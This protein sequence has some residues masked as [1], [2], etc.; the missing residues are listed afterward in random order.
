[1]STKK[2]DE[3]LEKLRQRAKLIGIPHY[4]L[5]SKENLQ[6]KVNLAL[7]D[8]AEAEIS[9]E[10]VADDHR[11]QWE[12]A[13]K[14]VRLRISN[15]NPDNRE[16]PGEVIT[17][18]SKVTGRVSKFVPFDPTFSAN[19]YHVPNII[20]K[21]LKNKKFVSR[22]VKTTNQ[23]GREEVI[24]RLVNEYALEVLPPLTYEELKDLAA[25][26]RNM[27]AVA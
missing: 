20:Y 25:K 19:G 7:M 12:D 4:H 13:M 1:M 10:E 23:H 24:T 14:L 2:V 27:E 18:Y 17:I 3:E 15:L 9:K 5:M 6:E 16:V 26:Q 8:K 11:A 21:F 22:T